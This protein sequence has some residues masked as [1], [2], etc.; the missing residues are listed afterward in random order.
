MNVPHSARFKIHALSDC[1]CVDS[2]EADPNDNK[3]HEP[4]NGDDLFCSHGCFLLVNL[5]SYTGIE[6]G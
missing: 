2:Y 3:D 5:M 4:P 6:V 1:W